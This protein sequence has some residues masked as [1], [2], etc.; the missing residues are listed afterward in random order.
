[1]LAPAYAPDVNV[2]GI[3]A[4]APASDLPA[5]V[6]RVKD[7]LEGRLLGGYIL[8]AYSDIYPDVS[9]DRYVRP[10]ARVIVRE[11]AARCLDRPEAYVSAVTKILS[12]QPIYASDPLSGALGNR[13]TENMPRGHIKAPVVIAQGLSD[14]LVLPS[15]QEAFV[16]QWCDAGQSLEY[17]TYKN[18][19]HLSVVFAG[20]ALIGD[21]LSWTQSRFSGKPHASG[22]TTA[23]K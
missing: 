2:A 13:L 18:R 10:A 14:P 6:G 11:A 12:R 4:I 16:K 20:S 9:F 3:A 8:S 5:L 21:L 23:A 22:C 19:D 1:M 17:R 7:T 15:V